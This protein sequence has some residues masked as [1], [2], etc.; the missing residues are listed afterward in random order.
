MEN[1]RIHYYD[2]P[3]YTIRI[4]K[5]FQWLEETRPYELTNYRAYVV[6]EIDQHNVD[7]WLRTPFITRDQ[8]QR[9]HIEIKFTMRDCHEFPGNARSCKETFT[10]YYYEA[11]YDFATETRPEW[12][13]G[14]WT[15]VDRI[16]ADA[17]RFTTITNQN[18]NV[19]R[20]SIPVSKKGLYFAFRDQGACTSI[21]SVKV[22]NFYCS[23]TSIRG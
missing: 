12:D 7:N 15:L 9:V 16:T 3:N 17:G 11:D 19:E 13:P 18:T 20:R 4:S 23:K 2:R 8:A 14:T 22:R 1:I 5:N 21:L 6:C 10:L